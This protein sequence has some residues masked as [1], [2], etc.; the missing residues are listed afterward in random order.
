MASLEIIIVN[1]NTGGL[2][3]ACLESM[4][5]ANRSAFQLKRVIVVDNASGDGSADG[6]ET[7][8]LPLLVLRQPINLGFGAACNE[9]A[10]YGQ[11]DY[12]LFLNPDTRLFTNALSAPLAFM[13]KP[14]N[15][16]IGIV[17]IQLVD[18]TGQISRTCARFPTPAMFCTEMLGLCHLLPHFFHGHFLK[19]WDHQASRDV[20][21]VMG[22]FFLVRRILFDAIGGFDKRFFVYLEDLDFSLRARKAGWRSFYLADAQAYHEGGGS[23]KQVKAARLFYALRSRILYGYKH[24]SVWAATGLMLGTL[25]FEPWTRLVWAAIRGSGREITATFKGYGM[26][27]AALPALFQKRS[28][29]A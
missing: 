27:W 20:D 14:D 22:A 12:L 23:S 5:R 2:L 11:A 19:G 25:F 3:R 16:N 13:E 26:L 15:Q 21:H 9:G 28:I 29:K 1:W 24:F 17:G 4:V 18:D 8:D 6:L 7:S 10:K